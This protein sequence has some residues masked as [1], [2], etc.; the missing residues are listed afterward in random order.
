MAG[1]SVHSATADVERGL[2]EK[3]VDVDTTKS[4]CV[5][6][7]PAAR[8]TTTNTT[9]V[10]GKS[11]ISRLLHRAIQKSHEDPLVDETP[12]DGGLRAWMILFFTHQVTANSFGFVTA[13]GVLQ[14]YYVEA[15]DLP[16]STVSWIGS[17]CAFLMLFMGAFSGRLSDAGYFPQ[18]LFLGTVIQI[19]GFVGASFSTTYWQILLSHGICLGFGGGLMLVPTMSVLGTYFTKRRPLVLAICVIGNNMGGLLYAAILQQCIPKVGYAWTMR[20][21]ALVVMCSSVPSNFVLKPMKMKRTKGSI[22]ELGAFREIEYSF[23]TIAMFLTFLG[24]WVPMFYLGSF[25]KNIIG[26]DSKTAGSLILIINGVGVAGRVL[27]ALLASR[28][29]P[30]NLMIPLTF[31]SAATLYCW[32]SVRTYKSVLLFDIFYG[33]IM[34]AGQGMLPPSLGSMTK[35]RSKMG[36]RM[37]MV[38]TACGVSLLIGQPLAG[39][40]IELD[41]GSYLYAQMYAGSSMML[42]A[43]FILAAR[44]R[45][46]GW[47]LTV[48]I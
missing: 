31:L 23:F 7:M 3:D 32:A 17:L 16:P 20:I 22:I 24:M 5:Q 25:G 44:V 47:D 39:A 15:L 34:A 18:V 10:T 4:P 29:G 2:D 48:R 40:L 14:S 37:G 13:F 45:V 9:A 6:E 46:G 43:L 12:P 30:L 19:I 21:C 35:D 8:P 1:I 27:P 42:G 33:F 38:F 28:L 11:L 41:G 36:V 26:I